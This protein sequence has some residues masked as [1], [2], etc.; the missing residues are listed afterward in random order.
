MSEGET[1]GSIWEAL[2]AFQREA[3][4]LQKNRINPHFGSRFIGLERLVE[5]IGPALV[6]HGLVWTTM[7]GMDGQGR[8]ALLYRLHHVGSGEAIDGLM[9]LLPVKADPQ[10]QG[11]AIT[12]ARRY[13]MMAVLGLV[14]DED[15]DGNAAP[16]RPTR[17]ARKPGAMSRETRTRLRVAR[18]QSTVDSERIRMMLGSIGV[19]PDTKSSDL[20]DEQANKLA[21][22]LEGE[23]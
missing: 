13:A 23:K 17:R 12:Y 3:P 6:K 11:S 14:A 1:H 21:E 10:A 16:E 7:P 20:T 4:R 18:E 19:D 22:L 9:A 15:D 5:L 2:L 8:P